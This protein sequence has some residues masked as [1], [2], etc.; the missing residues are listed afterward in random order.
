MIVSLPEMII[1]VPERTICAPGIIAGAP[2]IIVSVVEKIESLTS[3][4]ASGM[5]IFVSHSS[6]ITDDVE[7]TATQ[8]P[9][10]AAIPTIITL[11]G[12]AGRKEAG[13]PGV[14][15]VEQSACL[16]GF[17]VFPFMPPYRASR[18]PFL[19]R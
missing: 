17:V 1:S 9:L 12:K 18:V 13:E 6:T 19:T 15:D 3:L 10:I 14:S 8:T 16:V 2:S 7:L 4:I 5:E 11:K